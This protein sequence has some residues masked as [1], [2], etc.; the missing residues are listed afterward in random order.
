MKKKTITQHLHVVWL[1]KF[2]KSWAHNLSINLY[3]LCLEVSSIAISFLEHD[4]PIIFNL[5]AYC[6]I[7]AWSPAFFSNQYRVYCQGSFCSKILIQLLEKNI[8]ELG[9]IF[10]WCSYKNYHYNL[11]SHFLHQLRVGG[12]RWFMR[13]HYVVK[14][15]KHTGRGTRDPLLFSYKFT[16]HVSLVSHLSASQ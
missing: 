5:V 1:W 2:S 9:R 7:F 11:R 3:Q 15:F 16:I 14:L 12:Y 13:T 10:K 8:G 6:W 4:E